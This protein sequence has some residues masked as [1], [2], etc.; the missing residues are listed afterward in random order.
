MHRMSQKPK[1]ILFLISRVA[2]D[3][4]VRQSLPAHHHQYLVCLRGVFKRLI[5]RTVF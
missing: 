1:K 3:L 4:P 2:G 5:F